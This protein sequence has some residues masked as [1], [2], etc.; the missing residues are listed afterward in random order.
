MPTVLLTGATGFIGGA[1]LAQLL[2]SGIDCRVVLLVRGATPEAAADRVRQSLSRF[3][4]PARLEAQLASCRVI[5][6]DLTDLKTFSDPAFDDVTHV[7][8]LASNTSFRSVR[9]VRH[10]NILG[11]LTLAHRMRRGPRLKRF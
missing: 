8:H 6:G 7:L 3:V 2:Q 11:A 10:T 1:T 5:R 4:E 9:G